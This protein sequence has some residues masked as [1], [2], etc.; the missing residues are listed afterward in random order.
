MSSVVV[1]Y[2]SKYGA[3]K[4][5]ARWISEE[6][7][8]EI[9]ETKKASIDKIMKYDIIILGGGIYAQGIAGLSFIKKNQEK[10]KNKKIVVF[11]VGASPYEEK[12]MN[13]IK[14]HNFKNINY[15]IPC[16]YL[17]G[18]WFEDKMSFKD[19]TLCNMLKKVVAKK[20]PVDYEVWEKALM[21]AIGNEFDWTEKENIKSIIEYVKS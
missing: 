8:C 9:I 12:S 3:T 7:D 17:R 5:Y 11:A 15:E 10:L 18:A 13:A 19:K 16:F 4:K 14:E 6:L 1:M 20:D 2:Q 21:E